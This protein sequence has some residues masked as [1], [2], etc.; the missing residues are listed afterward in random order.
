MQRFR[1]PFVLG[2]AG[3]LAASPVVI[4]QDAQVK[5]HRMVIPHDVMIEMQQLLDETIS[6]DIA[7][8]ISRDVAQSMAEFTRRFGRLSLLDLAEQQDFKA[9]AVDRKTHTIGIGDNGSVALKNVVGDIRV[10]AGTGRDAVIEVVRT[11]RGRTDADAKLGLERVT[12]DVQTTSGRISVASVYPKEEQRTRPTYSVSTT[13]IVSV[14]AGTRL[15]AHSIAGNIQV[16]GVRG[17]IQADT[18]SGDLDISKAARVTNAR[19]VN[20]KVTLTGVESDGVVECG[21]M[22]GT[23]VLTDIKARRLACHVIGGDITARNV[24]A[25]GAEIST[26]SGDI[27]FAGPVSSKGRYSFKSHSGDVHLM[28]SGGYEFEGRSFSGEVRGEPG[29]TLT[30]STGGREITRATIGGGGGF[31]EATTFSGAVIVGRVK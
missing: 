30:R 14:P 29:V 4:A 7:R 17:D 22:S 8:Q 18:I 19:T 21:A 20:G 28:L 2:L 27:Q 1:L 12:V 24:Q 16:A 9:Q 5:R 3:A 6:R 10:K 25:E 23:V 15:E 31:V 13:Y 26:M 11:S